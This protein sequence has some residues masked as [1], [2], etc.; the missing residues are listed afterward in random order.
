MAGSGGSQIHGGSGGIFLGRLQSEGFL[1]IVQRHGF[2]II[3]GKPAQIHLHVLGIVYLDSIQENAYVLAAQAAD[4]DGLE[5]AC[6]AVVLDLDA[7]EA[8]EY[9]G[10]LHGRCHQGVYGD[11]LDGFGYGELLD[12]EYP[13]GFKTVCFLGFD[14]PGSRQ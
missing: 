13:G 8:P 11:F 9:F 1:G 7:G 4:V 12:G 3:H 6:P 14:A 10:Y 2:Q 5:P